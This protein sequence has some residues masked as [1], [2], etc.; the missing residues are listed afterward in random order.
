MVL[1]FWQKVGYHLRF[2]VG[3]EAALQGALLL[4]CQ[5]MACLQLLDNAEH[6]SLLIGLLLAVGWALL[7]RVDELRFFGAVRVALVNLEDVLV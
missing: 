4:G 5:L 6:H 1:W 2:C 3:I 7:V